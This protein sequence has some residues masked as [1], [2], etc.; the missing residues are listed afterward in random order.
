MKYSND[1]VELSETLQNPPKISV[2]DFIKRDENNFD[3][4]VKNAE[5]V[6][7]SIKKD[8]KFYKYA[9]TSIN[10]AKSIIPNLD[11]LEIMSKD[12]L[13]EIW[14]KNIDEI[15]YQ[16]KVLNKLHKSLNTTK[17]TKNLNNLELIIVTLG[18]VSKVRDSIAENY[19]R[20]ERILTEE[21]LPDENN[22]DNSWIVRDTEKV[23]L[24]KLVK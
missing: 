17:K 22:T 19:K 20:D 11:Y 12:E 16:L 15:K 4:N 8:L 10:I 6:L 3:K 7:K 5:E 13:D 23:V 24:R 14:S 21:I 1:V 2:F 18:Y 9:Y